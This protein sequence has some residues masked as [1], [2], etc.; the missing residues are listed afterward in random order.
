MK[1]VSTLLSALIVISASS[2][3]S[4]CEKHEGPAER[5]GKQID[6]SMD[7][8]QQKTENAADKTGDAMRNAADKTGKAI[9]N[10]GEKVQDSSKK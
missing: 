8:A 6:Q 10:A 3:L 7:K 5:A 4:A 1:L 2:L 9:E